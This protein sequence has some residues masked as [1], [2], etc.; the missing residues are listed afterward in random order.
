MT[1]CRRLEA[2]VFLSRMQVNPA[3]RG[4]RALMASPHSLHA[5]VLAAFPD[6]RPTVEGRVLWR[7]DAHNTHRVFLY[8]VSPEQPD[9]THLVEQAGW[10]TTQAWETTP[11]DR[12]LGS[13][14][15]GQ[16]WHFRLSANPVHSARRAN[17]DMTKPLAHVTVAQQEQWLLDRADRLGFA[18]ASSSAGAD[19]GDVGV[20]D[21]SVVDR[22]VRRFRRNGSRVTIAV[23]TFEGNLE[24]TDAKA[25]RRALTHGVGRA[26]AYGCGLLTLARPSAGEDR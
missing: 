4:A 13:L 8:T 15:A 19:K 16:R 14:T 12:L 3:R 23:A 20:S 10:P 26:K 11:Y 25:L 9:F 21:M 24:V 2:D 7:L 17:W 1:P 22:A 5:A 6:G 18:V